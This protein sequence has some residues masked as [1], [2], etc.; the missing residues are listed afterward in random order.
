M[1]TLKLRRHEISD[2]PIRQPFSPI[3]SVIFVREL[4]RA[5]RWRSHRARPEQHNDGLEPKRKQRS[6]LNDAYFIKAAYGQRKNKP[7]ELLIVDIVETANLAKT[8]QGRLYTYSAKARRDNVKG[9]H[10]AYHIKA[11]TK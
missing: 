2:L 7:T 8:A 5:P 4:Y 1:A 10:A 3:Y 9:A 6:R 11:A